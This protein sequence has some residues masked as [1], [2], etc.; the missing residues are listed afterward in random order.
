MVFSP[1]GNRRIIFLETVAWNFHLDKKE[2]GVLK[3]V[4]NEGLRA[5]GVQGWRSGESTRLPPMWPGFD[6]PTRRHM[7]VE[8]VGSLLC[9]ERFSPGSPVSP[10]LK[11]Q[12]LT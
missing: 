8:F 11:N 10:L 6:S 3:S 4:S 7:W 12:H 9:T 5:L 1:D 2:A